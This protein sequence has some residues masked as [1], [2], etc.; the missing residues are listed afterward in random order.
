[1][2]G[3]EPQL[4]RW[5]VAGV[6]A[7]AAGTLSACGQASE[8]ATRSPADSAEPSRRV[9]AEVERQVHQTFHRFDRYCSRRKVDAAALDRTTSDFIGWY[10]TYPARKYAV[11]I[12]DEP[13]TMLSAIL[14]LRYELSR[15]SPTHAARID[16]VLPRKML[17]GLRPLPDTSR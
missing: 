12:D 17:R 4:S 16:A 1:V 14:V 13:G 7:L 11:Q 3:A 15:C 2:A 10:R 5:R 8:S 9:P 6:A